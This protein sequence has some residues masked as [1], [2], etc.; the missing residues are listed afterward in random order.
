MSTPARS[1]EN[2]T[3]FPDQYT[4]IQMFGAVSDRISSTV[5][6]PSWHLHTSWYNDLSADHQKPHTL[7]HA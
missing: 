3:A 5:S 4:Y 2:L 6:S 1:S 7:T